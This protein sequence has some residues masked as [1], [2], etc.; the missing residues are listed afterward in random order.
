MP[1]EDGILYLHNY[2]KACIYSNGA[3]IN[4]SAISRILAL[5]V[6]KKKLPIAAGN[7]NEVIIKYFFEAVRKNKKAAKPIGFDVIN[8]Q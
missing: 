2:V 6:I 7:P 4:N 1:S 8:P 5:V 3:N